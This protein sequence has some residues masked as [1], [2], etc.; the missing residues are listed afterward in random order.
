M[1][2]AKASHFVGSD[3][4]YSAVPGQPGKYILTVNFYRDCG[5]IPAPFAVEVFCTPVFSGGM[6]QMAVLPFTDSMEVSE[7]CPGLPTECANPPGVIQG[8]QRYTYSDT[9]TLYGPGLWKFNFKDCCR[10]E[11]IINIFN[12]DSYGFFVDA[13][14]YHDT[15]SVNNSPTYIASPAPYFC[16]NDTVT[17]TP[18]VT[19]IDGDSLS[20]S[21][22]IPFDYTGTNTSV[23]INLMAG[24]TYSD[25]FGV[26]SP[27]TL[28]PATG[29]MQFI[30]TTVGAYVIVLKVEEWRTVNGLLIKIGE[31]R[32]DIQVQVLAC[33]TPCPLAGN[34]I[35]VNGNSQ[36]GTQVVQTLANQP[37]QIN[38]PAT[39]TNPNVTLTMTS[40]CALEIPG[41]SFVVSGSGS[42]VTGVFNWTPTAAHINS[43]PYY[44]SFRVQDNACPVP[45]ERYGVVKV[46]V[47][48][49]PSAVTPAV[50]SSALM[51]P[52]LLS[53]GQV[54]MLS[55]D[56]G[57]VDVKI[58][59]P[60]GKLVYEQQNYNNTWTGKSSA[61]GLYLYQL[62]IRETGQ[63][64]SGKVVL[65]K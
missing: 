30:P 62:R 51:L 6:A 14:L 31:T 1:P 54:F 18:Q 33:T 41:S 26:G 48:Q 23:P 40:N 20:F 42:N 21:F 58:M 34:I 39:S 52:N 50:A 11:G 56:L 45:N 63:V 27:V 17:Y 15:A 59:D 2:T 25:P 61:S 37:L 22:G 57:Q 49:A 32:R 3:F 53:A 5:G 9:V 24:Y 29:M 65:Q 64:I 7:V 4:G 8:I 12:S 44:F 35:A 55:A 36:N 38:I 28:D 10:N 19:D 13:F 60:T 46:Q 16:V 43:T 47:G